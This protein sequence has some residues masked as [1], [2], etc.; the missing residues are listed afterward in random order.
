MADDLPAWALREARAF[1]RGDFGTEDLAEVLV[2]ARIEGATLMRTEAINRLPW[3]I[4]RDAVAAL[5]PAEVA[6]KGKE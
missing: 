4:A 5:D 6:R 1:R 3:S 2:A